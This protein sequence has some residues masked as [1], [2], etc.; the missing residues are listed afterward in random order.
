MKSNVKREASPI[1]PGEYHE[2]YGVEHVAP[3]L[4]GE[5]VYG[6]S[7]LNREAISKA[8]LVANPGCY[9]ITSI[10]GLAPLLEGNGNPPK[11][12]WGLVWNSRGD[13]C[14]HLSF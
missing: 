5:A 12:E 11:N 3:D 1:T 7:E 4:L 13:L 10:L 9:V 8:R 14:F 6:V 2:A